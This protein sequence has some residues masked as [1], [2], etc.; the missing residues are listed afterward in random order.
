[1]KIA[2]WLVVL[3][4]AALSQSAQRPQSG[5]PSAPLPQQLPPVVQTCVPCH[6]SEGEGKPEAGFPRIAGQSAQYLAKQL[7]SYADG[8]RLDPTMEPI[9]RGLSPELRTT[10]AFHYAQL[11][12]PGAARPSGF[13]AS[14]A[15]R[16]RVLATIG[17]LER[18]VQACVN[19][20][21][22]GGIGQPPA[23]PYLAGLDDGYLRA[24]LNAWR[25]GRRKNDAGQQMA[26][27]AKALSPEDVAAV[28]RYYSSA[29][30]P[31]RAPLNLVQAGHPQ[32]M[33][34]NMS[35]SVMVDTTLPA[36]KG[37]EGGAS[38][39]GGNLGVGQSGEASKTP[40]RSSAAGAPAS[41]STSATPS[42]DRSTLGDA[43]RG[44]A[45][46]ASGVYGCTACH[47]VAGIRAPR[48]IVGPSLGGLRQR[49]FIAGQLPNTPDVLIAFIHNP[50]ALVPATAM[51]AVGLTIDDARD[52][53]AYLSTLA[54]EEERR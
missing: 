33:P 45:L 12:A 39:T 36:R 27:V 32:L 17:D 7:E 54:A 23:T 43:V 49:P 50:P 3:T 47:T 28:A 35:R 13:T 24:S 22:P 14:W 10:V 46:V 44:R 53:A 42:G 9:A 19:C 4:V 29:T 30:P 52:I 8:S 37:T 34:A 40:E 26:T 41:G 48:G 11:D 5:V 21:G 25:E 15:E 20:H 2:V 51:P 31:G 18:G 1:M 16:G 6:G 38:K